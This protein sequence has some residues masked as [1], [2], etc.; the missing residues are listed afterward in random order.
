MQ[1]DIVCSRI[2]EMESYLDAVREAMEQNPQSWWKDAVI[3]EK[4]RILEDYYENGQWLADYERDERGELPLELKRG[5]LS[6]DALYDLLEEAA[7]V[8]EISSKA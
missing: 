7:S 6:Q 1:P 8:N 5:V 3:R 4:L 2:A